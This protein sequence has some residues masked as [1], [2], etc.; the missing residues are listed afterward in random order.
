M[1]GSPITD[2]F[3]S[4]AILQKDFQVFQSGHV[5]FGTFY[6]Y[7]YYGG[8]IA[9]YFHV[10]IL[11]EVSHTLLLILGFSTNDFVLSLKIYA[12]IWL[13]FSQFLAYKLSMHYLK[14]TSVAWLISIG[15]AFST[16]YLSQTNG[17][18]FNFTAAAALLPGVLLLYEKMFTNPTSKNMGFATFSLIILF[19]ADLQITIFTIYYLLLRII[20]HIINRSSKTIIK[21]TSQSAVLFM[22]STAPFLLSFSMLQDTGGLAVNSIPSNYL[23]GASEFLLRNVGT[24]APA[25]DSIMYSLYIGTILFLLALIPVFLFRSQPKMDRKNYAFHLSTT[26]FFLLIAVGTALSSLVTLLF[27]RVPSRDVVLI[28]LS[29]C[30]CA[31]YG[32][33]AF[34]NFLSGKSHKAR[35]LLKNKTVATII[36][37]SLSSLVFADLTWEMFPVTSPMPTLTSGEIFVQNQNGDFRVLK[38]PMTWAYSNYE[39]TLLNHEIV[40]VSPIALRVYPPSSK[41]F[42][43]LT[44]SFNE[45]SKGSNIDIDKFTLLATLC[46]VKYIIVDQ[47]FTESS[48]YINLFNNAKDYFEPVFQDQNSTVYT[49]LYFQGIA[50]AVKNHGQNHGQQPILENLT[51]NEFSQQLI[52]DSQISVIKDFNRMNISVNVSQPAYVILSQGYNPSWNV[53]STN[54]GTFIE[55]LNLTAFQIN[56]GSYNFSASYHDADRTMYVHTT[57]TILL[58]LSCICLYANAKNKRELLTISLATLFLFG[59]VLASLSVISASE[60]GVYSKVMFGVGCLTSAAAFLVTVIN[61]LLKATAMLYRYIVSHKLKKL[62]A[63]L[64]NITKKAQSLEDLVKKSMKILLV[65]ILIPVFLSYVPPFNADAARLVD[66]TFIGGLL[67]TVLLYVTTTFIFNKEGISMEVGEKKQVIGTE[68][69]KGVSYIHLGVFGG[70]IGIVVSGIL[71]REFTFMLGQVQSTV[72]FP[73]FIQCGLLAGVGFGVLSRGNRILR[74]AIGCLLGVA[75]IIFSLVMA[76]S[77]PV[78]IGYMT[79]GF[80]SGTPLYLWHEYSFGCFVQLQIFSI[81]GIYYLFLGLFAAYISASRLSLP[82]IYKKEAQIKS[83]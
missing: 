6:L 23:T 78:I 70:F 47:N 48:S 65:I 66:D 13:L 60:F 63:K 64:Q 12:V 28:D 14:N 2:A 18:H 32:I 42:S 15:Y 41:V 82:T 43:L 81:R 17:G 62:E 54:T 10:S 27:I 34:K 19:F 9:T 79:S 22:L 20:Y 45:V 1:L 71:M 74:G 55:I 77:T 67:I 39:E 8:A 73:A 80:S 38:Y 33:L 30:I 72:Y 37:I 50:F 35:R 24:L 31:G 21:R 40:G 5:P 49:N 76:Y 53:R 75:A 4:L 11:P 25:G 51:I 57:F 44:D 61:K 83:I 36:I 52:N 7:D 26:V 56:S 69:S 59:I 46:A 16:F 29:V 58:A 3:Q 68:K